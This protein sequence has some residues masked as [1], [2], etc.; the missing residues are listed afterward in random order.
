M[1]AIAISLFLVCIAAYGQ[2]AP[3]TPS[4]VNGIGYVG[5]SPNASVAQ[6]ASNVGTAGAM[7]VPPTYMGTDST[8]ELP[9]AYIDFRLGTSSSPVAFRSFFTPN[10][11]MALFD[12]TSSKSN[13]SGAI[14]DLSE[15]PMNR[16]LVEADTVN[17][18]SPIYL[19]INGNV[20]T[21]SPRGNGALV[22]IMAGASSSVNDQH[23]GIEALNGIC[24]KGSTAVLQ[25]MQCFEANVFNN[26][27]SDSELNQFTGTFSSGPLFGI[28]ATAGG[29]NKM[30]SA[31]Q[32][33]DQGGSS[34]WYLGLN[35]SHALDG[36]I[37]IGTPY[38]GG[39]PA[40]VID[41]ANGLA[42][43]STNQGSIADRF[44]TAY[45]NG[46]F[47]SPFWVTVSG[48]PLTGTNPP[49]CFHITFTT[50]NPIDLC[51]DGTFRNESFLSQHTVA[52]TGSCVPTGAWVFSQDGHASFCQAGFWAIK[53]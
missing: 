14:G 16:W 2:N 53:L 7:V 30:A 42:T 44:E 11:S 50:G 25:Q 1:K 37:R 33:Q 41:S 39:S 6:T 32:V 36:G 20:T 45:W 51:S 49:I 3:I 4:S 40:G 46:S 38:A 27:N 28:S 17:D 15:T 19:D 47:S 22:G 10:N 48:Q 34:G 21:G 23:Y 8:T 5:P 18:P 35:I 13:Y 26:S 29:S 43:A 24:D 12:T 52:P 31:F 9:A